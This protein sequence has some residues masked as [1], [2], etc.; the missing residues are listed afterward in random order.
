MWVG[1][2]KR[3]VMVRHLFCILDVAC[4]E[5]WHADLLPLPAEKMNMSNYVLREMSW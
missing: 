3:S 2:E 5:T 4:L 1:V